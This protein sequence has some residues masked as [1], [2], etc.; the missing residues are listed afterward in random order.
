MAVS[1]AAEVEDSTAEEDLVAEADTTVV[2]S[3]IA[4]EDSE[5]VQEAEEAREDTEAAIVVAGSNSAILPLPT[6][7]F[8][9]LAIENFSFSAI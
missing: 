2:N 7:Y 3:I 4:G 9:L 5:E 6:H 8:P 1:E